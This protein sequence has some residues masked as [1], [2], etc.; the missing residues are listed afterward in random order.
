MGSACPQRLQF[1][2]AGEFL[3]PWGKDYNVSG[4]VVEEKG[5]NALWVSAAAADFWG[6]GVSGSLG[7]RSRRCV[8]R[9][10]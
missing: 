3:R 5:L 8:D 6:R 1:P 4:S 9:C 10:H 7:E 2:G